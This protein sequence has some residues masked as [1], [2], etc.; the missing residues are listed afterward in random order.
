L[1]FSFWA[2][3]FWGS[4]KNQAKKLSRLGPLCIHNGPEIYQK[5]KSNMI[6]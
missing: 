6:T 5:I 4:L 3:A 1:D 2:G